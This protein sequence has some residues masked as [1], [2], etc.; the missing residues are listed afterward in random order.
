M[1]D[2]SR[3]GVEYFRHDLGDGERAA[4]DRVLGQVMLTTGDVTAEFERA[5]A[6]YLGVGHV[7]GLMSCTHA[8]QLGLI[9]CG[10]GLF[11]TVI[12]PLIRKGMHGAE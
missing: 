7:V 6:D 5:F 1:T 12:S 3:E 2:V 8:L 4:L 10:V 11:L 9:A